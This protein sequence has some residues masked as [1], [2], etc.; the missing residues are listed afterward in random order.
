MEQVNKLIKSSIQV[1]L[2]NPKYPKPV[3][4]GT[5]CMINYRDRII[6]I[7]VSHVTISDDLTT[8]LETN[9]PPTNNTTEIHTVGGLMYFDIL[10]LNENIDVNEL[11]QVLENPMNPLDI[12]F[13]E[14]KT[15]FNLKQIE[16]NT[17]EIRINAGDKEI[18][19]IVDI[20]DPNS[21]E[22]YGFF[23]Y[24]NPFYDGYFL[25]KTPTLKYPLAFHRSKG[26]M[27]MFVAKDI[28]KNSEEYKG[29][30]GAPILDSKGNIVALACMVKVDSKII[31]GFSFKECIKL[32]DTA[33]DTNQL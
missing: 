12:T 30:S 5:G 13:A 23:G 26:N 18:L 33:I 16:I 8:Y 29:C 25:G 24:I 14:F 31:Y 7:S 28:I 19:D 17:P 1:F 22:T 32:I 2:A 3:G 9:L 15:P 6:F 20:V 21:N 4:F 27:L 10:N 11:I